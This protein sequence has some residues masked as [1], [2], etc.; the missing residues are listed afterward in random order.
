LFDE[1][2]I[3]FC[4]KQ[5]QYLAKLEGWVSSMLS[6]NVF[7]TNNLEVAQSVIEATLIDW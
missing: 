5:V 7:Q 1:R 4:L 2:F 6:C 3:T